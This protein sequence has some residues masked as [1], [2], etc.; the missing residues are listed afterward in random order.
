MEQAKN[1]STGY[2]LA[3]AVPAVALFGTSYLLGY[4]TTAGLSFFTFL[5][6]QDYLNAAAGFLPAVA[7]W[8]AFVLAAGRFSHHDEGNR[9]LDRVQSTAQ[10]EARKKASWDP[11]TPLFNYETGKWRDDRAFVLKAA[12]LLAFLAFFGVFVSLL[13]AVEVPLVLLWASVMLFSVL[14]QWVLVY[15]HERYSSGLHPAYVVAA[16]LALYIFAY[17]VTASRLDAGGR[18]EHFVSMKDSS[19][20]AVTSLRRV[21][22]HIV[23][24]DTVSRAWVLVPQSDVLRV[25]ESTN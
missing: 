12:T 9:E 15:F 5:D 22:Q 6:F 25:S 2:V 17:G 24:F 1:L 14:G 13:F 4:F 10:I 3:A 18:A 8:F 23:V 11:N 20:V 21:G 19:I 16:M 7:I